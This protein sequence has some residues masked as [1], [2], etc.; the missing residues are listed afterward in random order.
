MPIAP[1]I[2]AV[3]GA[4]ATL[5]ASNRAGKAAEGQANRVDQLERERFAAV[6]DEIARLR[7]S[8]EEAQ[9]VALEEGIKAE[10]GAARF[11]ELGQGYADRARG[12][13]QV[14]E[15]EA[16][17]LYDRIGSAAD[18]RQREGY[19]AAEYMLDQIDRGTQEVTGAAVKAGDL[20]QDAFTGIEDRYSP[21]LASERS[22]LGQLNAEFGLG[23]GKGYTGYRESPAYQ[24]AQDASRVA[25]MEAI[26]TINQDA[27]NQGTLYSGRR[28]E[29]LIDRARRGSYER[30]GIEQTYYQNYL[31]MLQDM[32]RPTATTAVSG[33]EYNTAN[34]AGQN[35]L[36]AA[37]TNLSARLGGTSEA[38]RMALGNLRTGEEGA[39]LINALPTGTEGADI[40]LGTFDY[41]TAGTP[42]RLNAAQIPMDINTTAI[43][44]TAGTSPTG[45]AGADLRLAGVGAQNAAISDLVRGGAQV[46]SNYLN[47]PQTITPTRT[48]YYGYG[49]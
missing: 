6:Q 36:D 16:R 26:D 43:N 24:A 44:A 45:R 7:E 35:Y 12:A 31:N 23:P 19:R 25:E 28:G 13:A 3:V 8:G 40:A 22:A 32:A 39:Y 17:R 41:G 18:T 42:Y 11:A 37:R 47:R 38:A 34:Q 30:A 5:Y 4:G 48:P 9:A 21:Y 29:A 1:F 15:D 46:Y 2:P 20:L 14:R 33:Y 27:A 10:V 49:T